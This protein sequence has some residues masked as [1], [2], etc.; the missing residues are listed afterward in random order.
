MFSGGYLSIHASNNKEMALVKKDKGLYC[1]PKGSAS[2]ADEPTQKL[3][4]MEFHC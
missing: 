2:A 1:I 3:T 4:V